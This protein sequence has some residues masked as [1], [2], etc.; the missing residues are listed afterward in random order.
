MSTDY[1]VR[2]ANRLQPM[3]QSNTDGTSADDT[4]EPPTKKIRSSLFASY[5]RRNTLTIVVPTTP[6]RCTL[7]AYLDLASSSPKATIKSL[8]ANAQFKALNRFVS[9][10]YCVSATSA[11]VERVFSHGGIFM[12]PHRARLS[13]DM[14]CSLVFSK[15]NAHL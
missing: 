10:I 7:Q 8:I 4:S 5:A 1:I 11:P 3:K 9:S 15:C 6:L 13:D 14:L 12:H 2:E